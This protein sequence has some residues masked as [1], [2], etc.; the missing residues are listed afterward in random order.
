MFDRRLLYT[1]ISI[2]AVVMIAVTLGSLPGRDGEPGGAAAVSRA[3]SQIRVES[4]ENEHAKS[5][6]SARAYVMREHNGQIAV[7]LEGEAEPLMLL[8]TRTKFLPEFD[9]DQLNEGIWV[10]D[11]EELTRLIE[12]YIS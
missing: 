6:G 5:P 11:F 10:P 3:Q 1:L 8:E 4:G 12:D 9:R 2:G 7:Y